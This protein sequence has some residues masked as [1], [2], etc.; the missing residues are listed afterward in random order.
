M[1]GVELEEGRQRML[2]PDDMLMSELEEGEVE[3]GSP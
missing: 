3:S 2:S 1:A